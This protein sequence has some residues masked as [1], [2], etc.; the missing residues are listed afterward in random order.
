MDKGVV[1]IGVGKKAEGEARLCAESVRRSNPGL[2]VMILDEPSPLPSP[3]APLPIQQVRLDSGEGNMRWSR[4]MKVHLD[5]L[6]PFELTLYLD[7]DTRAQLDLSEGFGM[8]E[9]GFDLTL[10]PSNNQGDDLMW[11]VGEE[12]RRR[13]VEELG[14]WPL[15]LQAGVMFFRKSEGT[16]RLFEAWQEEWRRW[17]GQDQAAL[18]RALKRAPVRMW[19]LGRPWNGGAAV[20]HLFG[21]CRGGR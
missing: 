11:H 17:E 2:E 20:Q 16:R 6:S 10:T 1:I 13:T 18:L 5:E 3:P 12:E 14:F 9:D 4:W 7:A 8:L 19:L 21:R 15:Q